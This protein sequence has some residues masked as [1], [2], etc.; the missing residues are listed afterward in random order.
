MIKF[1][2]FGLLTPAEKN[3]S[4]PTEFEH[5][6]VKNI[7]NDRRAYLYTC[8]LNYSSALKTVCG[9]I[10]LHQW[11]NGSFVTKRKMPGDI[12]LVTF[13][14]TRIIAA[15]STQLADFK[16]SASLSRFNVDAYIIE[17]FSAGH[18][19]AFFTE[20]DKTYWYDLFTK[21]KRDFRAA[22]YPKDF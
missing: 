20:S 15:R 1:N 9:D 8:Y 10:E 17:V 22:N 3:Q 5:E 7:Y 19:N 13:I 12:D 16:F 4:D 6:F 11:I 2:E 21:T 14:D 18:V